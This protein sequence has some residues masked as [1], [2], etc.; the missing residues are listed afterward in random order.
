MN[1]P[2]DR[3][4]DI[5]GEDARSVWSADLTEDGDPL[6]EDAAKYKD[7]V[8]AWHGLSADGEAT[9]QVGKH[10]QLRLYMLMICVFS[11]FTSIM[12]QKRTTMNWWP[13]V[14]ILQGKSL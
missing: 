10:P 6:D 7:A 5:L 2:L 13:P 4:L 14:S 8:P 3:S 1:T 11:L 9:G 12:E